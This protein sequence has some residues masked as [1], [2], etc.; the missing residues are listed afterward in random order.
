MRI[1]SQSD[2]KP[3]KEI[4]LEVQLWINR[5]WKMIDTEREGVVVTGPK[6]IK[7]RTIFCAMIGLIFLCLFHFG[8]LF[9]G[10]GALFILLAVVDYKML[11]KAPTKFFP[12]EGE[13]KRT[14]ER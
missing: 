4:P 6:E 8:M 3:A 7:G 1:G 10:M 5:G 2:D 13:R 11:T 12:A 14:L 9:P